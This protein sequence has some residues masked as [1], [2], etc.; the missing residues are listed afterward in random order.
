MTHVNTVSTGRWKNASEDGIAFLELHF[1]RRHDEVS[2][3]SFQNSR[4][5]SLLRRRGR[6]RLLGGKL[7]T[8]LRLFQVNWTL[9]LRSGLQG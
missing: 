8:R 6:N 1:R 4:S 5:T 9:E 7:V 2:T 3:D